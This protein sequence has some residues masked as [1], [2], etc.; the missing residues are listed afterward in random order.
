MYPYRT[1]FV[2]RSGHMFGCNTSEWNM[3]LV[4]DNVDGL[5]RPGTTQDN[6]ERVGTVWDDLGRRRTTSD[7][8]GRP[9]KT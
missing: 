1:Y 7:N 8:L 6:L 3:S 5:G 2:Y 9:G 4:Y